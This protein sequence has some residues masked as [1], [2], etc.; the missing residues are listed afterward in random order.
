MRDEDKG[1]ENEEQV[2][3]R[4]RTEGATHTPKLHLPSEAPLHF[5]SAASLCLASLCARRDVE[6]SKENVTTAGMDLFAPPP[7][8]A[9]EIR[10]R[11]EREGVKDEAGRYRVALGGSSSL[12]PQDEGR[13]PG[14]SLAAL[15]RQAKAERLAREAAQ[16]ERRREKRP[17][18]E[19]APRAEPVPVAASRAEPVAASRAEPVAASRLTWLAVGL[20]V[21][22]LC[23]EPPAL[24]KAK[25]V[26]RSVE[27]DAE[28][29]SAG[30][31][32]L[33]GGESRV[34]RAA[35]LQT[36]LPRLGGRVEVVE[37]ADAGQPGVLEALREEAF[38]CR[39]RL[40]ESG[41]VIEVPYE[42]VCKL[43]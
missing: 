29:W 35:E 30:V 25:G 17:R 4:S 18:E 31:Q 15:E 38:A 34:C 14:V 6:E 28:G 1:N 22:L 33:E 24:Y 2:L 39:V 19:E 11:L 9:A 13:E 21:K 5:I 27:R 41:K 23:R 8:S 12:R 40:A 3:S 37:G 36:V 10:A 32:L 16:R 43:E 26:V 42:S 7:A 20:V